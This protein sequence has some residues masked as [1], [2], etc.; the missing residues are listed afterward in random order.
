MKWTILFF[1]LLAAGCSSSSVKT[2]SASLPVCVEQLDK[3]KSVT[4]L[5]TL[6]SKID[7]H[8]PKIASRRGTNGEVFVV[9]QL[10]NDG[11]IVSACNPGY[12]PQ[13]AILERA[14]VEDLEQIRFAPHQ[15]GA[16]VARFAYIGAKKPI[17]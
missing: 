7:F 11:K 17:F 15:Q 1:F 5:Y 12:S 6:D 4:S 8:F 13:P 3:I 10:D 9:V 2:D 14:A 16:Y